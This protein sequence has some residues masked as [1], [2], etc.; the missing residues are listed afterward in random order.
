MT[1]KIFTLI[2]FLFS[3][4]YS[5]S[6]TIDMERIQFNEIENKSLF[7]IGVEIYQQGIDLS[8]I[9]V[10]QSYEDILNFIEKLPTNQNNLAV[11]KIVKKILI[12]SFSTENLN[13]DIEQDKNLFNLRINKLFE[14][15]YFN[16]IDKIYSLTPSNLVNDNINLKRVESYFL[17]NEYK[18]GCQIIKEEGFKK[19]FIFGKFEIICSIMDQDFEKARFSLSLLKELNQPGDNL[20]IDLCY[21][22]MGD[23]KISDSKNLATSLEKISSLNPILLSSLQIAEI[24]PRFEHI[25]NAPT[26]FLTF[27]LSS[28]SSSIEL[29][30]YTSEILV[31]Q[32]RI[33]NSMLAEI[34]QLI[35]FESEEVESALENFK[36]L[37]PVRA[38]SLLYQALVVEKN[39]E[40]KFQIIKN[41]LNHARND[42]LFANIS[43]LVK[44]SINFFEIQD[45]SFI[46]SKLI[47]DMYVATK[48]FDAAEKFIE[49]KDLENTIKKIDFLEIITSLNISKYIYNMD[50][51]DLFLLEKYI[52]QIIISKTF[53]KKKEDIL[54]LSTIL[55]DLN[56]SIKSKIYKVKNS[57][58]NKNND[59][60]FFNLFLGLE[61]IEKKNYFDVFKIIFEIF[62]EKD[63]N[64]I[65]QIELFI[66]LKIFLNFELDQELKH[67]SNEIL[68]YR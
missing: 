57:V 64:E 67:L 28:P 24:S 12:S 48:N 23:I 18:N 4:L 55:F 32:K 6:Q 46:D 37:S 63:V 61:A 41:L 36:T 43:F 27:I 38:R 5:F 65:N 62:H 15:A 16:E 47:V 52:D 35:T 19:S 54:M 29:K 60:N 13:L 20:F 25:K 58:S 1:T 33:D 17:R 56:K 7:E 53:D 42:K 59:T 26:S 30:L 49:K 68:M 34:Y 39:T 21:G 66:L 22:I 40:I 14:L 45:L 51:F 10:D 8:N 31:K 11:Q 3:P 50:N 44:D 9:F 2:I